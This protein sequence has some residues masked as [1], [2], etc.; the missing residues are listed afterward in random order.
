MG[1]NSG[2]ALFKTGEPELA[3]E[4]TPQQRHVRISKKMIAQAG[5]EASSSD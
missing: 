1:C 4:G 3:S 2:V 5:S